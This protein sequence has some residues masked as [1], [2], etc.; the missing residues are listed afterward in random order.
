MVINVLDHFLDSVVRIGLVAVLGPPWAENG[1]CG[2]AGISSVNVSHSFVGYSVTKV[3]RVKL[4]KKADNAC[5]DDSL[6]H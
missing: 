1:V 2:A 4:V 5:S 6:V 3:V